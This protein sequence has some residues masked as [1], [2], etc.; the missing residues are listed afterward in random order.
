MRIVL[1]GGVTAER[2]PR[3]IKGRLGELASGLYSEIH[4][5][6]P[7]QRSAA[8]RA[9]DGLTSTNCGW[10]LYRMSEV[11]RGFIDD[12]STLRERKARKRAQLARR[13]R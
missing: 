5:M 11:L 6:T 8:L 3:T 13:A 12:A 9:L 10:T 4:K 1:C 2:T 7:R